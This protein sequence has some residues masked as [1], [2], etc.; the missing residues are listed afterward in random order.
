MSDSTAQNPSR[1]IAEWLILLIDLASTAELRIPSDSKTIVRHYRPGDLLRMARDAIQLGK[2]AKGIYWLLNPLPADWS[3]GTA[4]DG[5]IVRRRWLLVDCDPKRAG[6]VS[7]TDDEKALAHEKAF[8]VATYLESLGWPNPIIADSG[9]GWHLLYR[10]D[11]PAD[12]G[13]LVTRILNALAARFSDEAVD[14]DTK[15]GNA[16]RICKLYGTMAAKG[17]HTSERPH[18][19]SKIDSIPSPLIPVPT[20]LLKKLAN[21]GETPPESARRPQSPPD[22]GARVSRPQAIERARSYLRMMDASISGEHG[23]DKL[24][25]AASVLVNDFELTDGEALDLL[26]TEFN[27]RCV[28]PWEEAELVRKIGESKKAPPTRPLKAVATPE[29]DE[30][31]TTFVAEEPWPSQLSRDAFHGIAGRIVSKIEPHSEADPAALL[32]QL[33]VAVGNLSG[34]ET[35]CLVESSRHYANLFSVLIGMS[36][37][38]RKGTAGDH[39]NRLIKMVDCDWF[40]QQRASGLV[41][42]EGLIWQVR[43]PGV[44]RSGYDPGVLDKRL[45]VQESEF[46]SVLKAK[47]REKNTLGE[48]LRQSWDSGSLRTAGKNLP[49]KA[50]DAHISLIGHITPQELRDVTREVD[51][52]NG[53]ANRILWC[54]VRRSK[55]LPEGGRIESVDFGTEIE[56]LKRVVEFASTE[57]EIVRDDQAKR[58]WCRVYQELTADRPGTFGAICNRAA[59]QVVRLSLLYAMLDQSKVIKLEHLRAAL[60]VWRFCEASARYAF[61]QSLSNRVA[62]AILHELKSC[63]EQGMSRTA[64]SEIFKRNKS[65]HELNSALQLLFESNLAFRRKES[66]GGRASEMWFAVDH[67]KYIPAGDV[68]P[69]S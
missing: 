29:F 28:P 1:Q 50:T 8:E 14:I 65:K 42:G 27:P 37:T 31:E 54:C 13:G 16:S 53:L 48:V 63:G 39:V 11:L 43:D 12:D 9:N 4:K 6:T 17:E 20:E 33:L 64:I 68:P 38:G 5:D 30:C 18:R 44:T 57:Q 41:S 47:N 19:V 49:A 60:A 51:K 36:S 40:A 32:I 35:Y 2:G 23:H 21:E 69:T 67:R 25:K 61:G 22:A 3:G 26:A 58:E 66:T 62:D 52:V 10:I 55:M 45:F 46:S 7:S 34:R 24:L 59:P 15:V 56:E